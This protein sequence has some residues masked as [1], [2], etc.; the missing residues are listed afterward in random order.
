MIQGRLYIVKTSRVHDRW[1]VHRS[2]KSVH[3]GDELMYVKCQNA[4]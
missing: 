2:M 1:V 4:Q 3:I